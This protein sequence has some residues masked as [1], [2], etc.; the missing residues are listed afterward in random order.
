MKTN[1][2]RFAVAIVLLAI[3]VISACSKNLNK[4]KEKKVTVTE[5]SNDDGKGTFPCP[6]C[7]P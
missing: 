7:K 1:L 4:P 6:P 2:V 5:K 3:V